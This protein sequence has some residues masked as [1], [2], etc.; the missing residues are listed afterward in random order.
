MVG[1][2]DDIEIEGFL[3]DFSPGGNVE[4]LHDGV[5][6][7]DVEAVLRWGPIVYR[8]LPGRAASHAIIGRDEQGHSLII[9]IRET[10]IA[11]IW[12]PI[13]GWRSALAHRLIENEER[14]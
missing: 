14:L 4:H 3:W 5:S 7:E 8:N 2:R 10:S 12:E 1:E 6:P 13:T 9:Y 11:G